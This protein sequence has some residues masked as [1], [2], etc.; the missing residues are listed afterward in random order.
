MKKFFLI[1]PLAIA[2]CGDSMGVAPQSNAVS[3]AYAKPS[4]LNMMY[5]PNATAAGTMFRW[6]TEAN[7]LTRIDGRAAPTPESP[8]APRNIQSSSI[9]GL[10]LSGLPLENFTVVD[11]Q[12]RG[13]ISTEVKD[14]VRQE[15]KW[16]I[17]AL[18]NYVIEA[19]TAGMTTEQ[20]NREFQPNDS[21]YR[22]V[23][24]T[25]QELTDSVAF[26]FG[27]ADADGNVFSFEIDLGEQEIV[28]ATVKAL[29]TA[30][31]GRPEGGSEARPVCF[32]GVKVYDPFIQGPEDLNP[33]NISWREIDNYDQAAL[34]E[35]FRRM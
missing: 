17:S 22:T 15:Y 33:G 10:G 25:S 23:F 21:R 32:I 28:S 24:V 29:T 3:F 8:A 20:V 11:A 27:G 14:S 35:A 19:K 13:Q 34:S 18:S 12:L 4:E 9:A 1:V 6:N 7:T 31:C 26:R 2:S 30:S 16:I 5:D